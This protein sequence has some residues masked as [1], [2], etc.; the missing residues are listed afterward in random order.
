MINA[1]CSAIFYI[2]YDFIFNFCM[3]FISFDKFNVHYANRRIVNLF[4]TL[5]MDNTKYDID[6]KL[7]YTDQILV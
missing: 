1:L 7:Y 4:S 2:V 6:I 5:R 3:V